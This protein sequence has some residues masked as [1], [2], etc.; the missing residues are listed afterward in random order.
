MAREPQR[1]SA[2][3]LSAYVGQSLHPTQVSEG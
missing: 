2:F 1:M 3:E